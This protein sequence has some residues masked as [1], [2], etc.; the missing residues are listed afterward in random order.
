MLSRNSGDETAPFKSMLLEAE[1]EGCRSCIPMRVLLNQ[2]AHL[3]L[4][5]VRSTETVQGT[6]SDFAGM[7]EV[8][9]TTEGQCGTM[10]SVCNHPEMPDYSTP[11]LSALA[12]RLTD[13]SS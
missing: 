2:I 1:P 9:K 13:T 6:F 7:C 3:A 11:E 5:D 4:L 10:K 12:E 8:G